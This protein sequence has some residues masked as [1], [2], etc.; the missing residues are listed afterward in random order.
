MQLLGKGDFSSELRNR[1]RLQK[2]SKEKVTILALWLLSLVGIRVLLG[3]ELSNIWGT[4]G[5]VAITFAI[6]YLALR[7]TPFSRYSNA[8]NLALRDW[9]SKRYVLL[10]L[11]ASMVVLLSLMILA[12]VGY[13]FHADKVVSIWDIGDANS[14]G[15][16]QSKLSASVNALLNQGYSRMD[17][18]AITVASVD[19][20]LGGHYVQSTSFILAEDV[21]ILAFLLLIKRMGQKNIFSVGMGQQDNSQKG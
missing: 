9:Y 3:L 14:L 7:Y 2:F 16:T 17:A 11:L 8:V 5:A 19:K 1:G 20:S 15:T 21:E 10:G 13:A 18:L 12:E 4:T 6:F